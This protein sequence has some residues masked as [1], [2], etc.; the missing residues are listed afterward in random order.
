MSLLEITPY[1]DALEKINQPIAINL[2][3]DREKYLGR[4]LHTV[5]ATCLL[6]GRAKSVFRLTQIGNGWEAWRR[7][8]LEYEPKEGA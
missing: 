7:I 5:L 1:L 8:L 3:T 4:L 6:S 2:C